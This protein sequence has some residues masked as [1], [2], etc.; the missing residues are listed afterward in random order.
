MGSVLLG[1]V[2][3]RTARVLQRK[4]MEELEE[5]RE[6]EGEYAWS[7]YPLDM[8]LGLFQLLPE[9]T[10]FCSSKF[11]LTGGAGACPKDRAP[12]TILFA[13]CRKPWVL[14]LAGTPTSRASRCSCPLI[15]AAP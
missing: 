13:L 6:K 15:A 14:P 2:A 3:N 12:K 7:N 8:V 10:I 11:L 1:M 5:E 9:T 4:E